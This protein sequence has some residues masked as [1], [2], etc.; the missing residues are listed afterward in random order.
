MQL[1][2]ARAQKRPGFVGGS[3]TA[4]QKQAAHILGKV[5]FRA[6]WQ[7]SIVRRP[8]R[9]MM[10]LLLRR[11]EWRMGRERLSHSEN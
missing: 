8:D 6:R 7:R 9:S 5:Q 2:E 10:R 11:P 4:N 1:I 3:D